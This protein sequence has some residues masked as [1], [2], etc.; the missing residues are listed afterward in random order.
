VTLGEKPA[1]PRFWL[2]HPR[3]TVRWRLTLLYGGLF[4]ASGVA[5][6]AITYTLV[7]H[8]TFGRPG[9][10]FVQAQLRAAGIPGPGGPRQQAVHP[11]G[12]PPAA[13]NR[14][15]RLL[16]TSS[17]R[18]AVTFVGSG[19]RIAD[20]HQLVIE[21]AIA[22]AIMAVISAALGWLVARRVLRPLRTMTAATQQ[23]S[24]VNLHQRLAM[25]GPRDELREL[26]DTIDGLLQRLE[27]A[28]TAQRRFVANA[29]HELRTPLTVARALLEMVIRDP[30]AT[31]ETYRLTC[32]QVLEEG[33]Q[34]EQLIDAL[35]TLAQGQR[36]I[37]HIAAL[38]LAAITGE[39][40]RAREP[41]LAALG[42]HLDVSLDVAP[43]SGDRRLV[44]RLVSNLLENALGHNMPNGHVRVQVHATAGQA[45]LAISNSGP[46]V[47]AGE[48]DRLLQPFQRMSADRVGQRDGL[49]LGL[50]LSIVTAI[51][52]A[53]DAT[54]D[55]RPGSDGGLE[56][57]VRFPDVPDRA[58]AGEPQAAGSGLTTA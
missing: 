39:V 10:H 1:G 47:P 25:Q 41:D 46:L 31:V 9:P 4:L 52:S 50:G 2:R 55:V 48:V 37:D 21:S 23:I 36:R 26:A 30:D 16:G 54:L 6:L 7:D 15:R 14:L 49:G 18:T 5:L 11:G 19:Q 42:L 12:P 45:T 40:L 22:L 32:R 38:D 34:Q 3:T 28:F 8:A 51:A 13:L 17:G 33:D 57:E 44:E 27:A 20:L 56:V 53:H 29:S 58:V 35:L 43:F 24:E